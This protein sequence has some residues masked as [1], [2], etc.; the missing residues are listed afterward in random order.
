MHGTTLH[1]FVISFPVQ[2]MKKRFA[3]ETRVTYL[4]FRLSLGPVVEGRHSR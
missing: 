1:L 2:Y 3:L 4:S